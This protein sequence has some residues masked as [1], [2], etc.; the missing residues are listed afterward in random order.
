M[1]KH[2]LH[3]FIF[4]TLSVAGLL[5]GFL[6][7]V[8]L[9]SSQTVFARSEV[10]SFEWE[11]AAPIEELIEED[12]GGVKF[13][14]MQS[15]NVP[16][17]EKLEAAGTK[18]PDAKIKLLQAEQKQYQ[19][20]RSGDR[21]PASGSKNSI[22]V[23]RLRMIEERLNSEVPLSTTDETGT[24]RDPQSESLVGKIK[25]SVVQ[26]VSTG[27]DTVKETSTML[28]RGITAVPAEVSFGEGPREVA[29]IQSEK[30]FI[31]RRLDLLKG[32]KTRVY[33]SG[34]IDRKLAFV[35]D[36]FNIHREIKGNGVTVIEFTP[37]AAGVHK[38]YDPINKFEG[39]FL[40]R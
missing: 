7:L 25:D 8:I 30:G 3:S 14:P 19:G 2:I 16:D 34:V 17:G 9:L 39:W 32:V 36:S 37:D 27:I 40:V 10:T 4:G 29:V 22:V 31:P 6:F 20:T 5:A 13:Y 15:S 23:D 28:Y 11:S 18:P 38:F 1:K 21:A 24:S 26:G 12:S 35:N 33:I